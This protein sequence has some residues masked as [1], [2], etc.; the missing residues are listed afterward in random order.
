[1][2][3]EDAIQRIRQIGVD[4]ETINICY[5]LDAKR[6]LVGTVALRYLLISPSDAIIGDIMHENVIYLNHN[7]SGRIFRIPEKMVDIPSRIRTGAG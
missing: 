2:T 7:A 5:V 1:M 6:T 3:V 4:S